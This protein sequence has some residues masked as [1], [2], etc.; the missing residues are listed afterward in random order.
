MKLETKNEVIQ[1]ITEF[2]YPMNNS[3]A[4]DT[5]ELYNMWTD[6]HGVI[7]DPPSLMDIALSFINDAKS[8]D[9][10]ILAESYILDQ[11]NNIFSA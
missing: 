3:S 2:L 5:I 11:E 10:S 9:K 4:Y 6:T 1:D 7:L 8:L